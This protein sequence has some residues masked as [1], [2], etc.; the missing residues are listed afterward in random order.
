LEYVIRESDIQ[1]FLEE[2]LKP[3]LKIYSLKVKSAGGHFLIEV[4]LDNLNDPRGSVSLTDCEN[5]SHRLIEQLEANFSDSNYTLQVSSAG[6]EREL[7]LP[8]ELGRFKKL[9]LKLSFILEGKKVEKTFLVLEYSEEKVVLEP[10]EKKD[11]KS[12]G[13]KL[14]MSPKDILKGNLFIKI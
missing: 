2:I 11:K 10:C 13:V 9:P 8:D 4:D 12:L 5:V 3:P 1:K 7:K 14:E 6:A